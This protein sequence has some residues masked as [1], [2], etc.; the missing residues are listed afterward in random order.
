MNDMRKLI[1]LF[2]NIQAVPGLNTGSQLGGNKFKNSAIDEAREP[3]YH[4]VFV[5]LDD[6]SWVHQFDAD[7]AE[8]A[9]LEKESQKNQGYKAIVIRVPK[10]QADWRI[11]DTDKFVKD[12]LA[13]RA[14]TKIATKEGL[15]NSLSVADV[16]DAY[17]SG[18]ITYNEFMDYLSK[19]PGVVAPGIDTDDDYTDYTMRQGEMGNP[20]R[21]TEAVEEDPAIQQGYDYILNA[22][23]AFIPFD[24]ALGEFRIILLKQGYPEKSIPEIL[25]QI[26]SRFYDSVVEEAHADTCTQNN[27]ADCRTACAMEEDINNGYKKRRIV[28]GQDFF[29]NGADGPV[30]DKTGPSAAKQ[31]D[32]P[33]Q[34]KMQVAETHKELVYSYRKYLKESTPSK[35]IGKKLNENKQPV[36]SN[37]EVRDYNGDFDNDG[38]FITYEGTVSLS[39]DSLRQD[40][41]AIGIDYDIVVSVKSTYHWEW[42]ESPTGYNY[43]NDTILYSKNTY[44]SVDEPVFA[45]ISLSTEQPIIVGDNE[46]SVEDAQQVLDPN[47][48]K[49]VLDPKLY[50]AFFEKEMTELARNDAANR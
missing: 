34:K 8:D 35:P 28:D 7:D 16:A 12:Y 19:G 17:K 50:R 22:S 45:N 23:N 39:A 21:F 33:E 25:N 48:F 41:Q 49:A 42:D 20:D 38:E 13:S 47:V 29:P 27:T 31:G 1:N 46:M 11:K 14:T 10:S 44:V 15:S 36:I 4:S 6:G 43:G 30:V 3:M 26:E 37:V 18:K 9:R 5:Q 2:E 40:G 24:E 32:N